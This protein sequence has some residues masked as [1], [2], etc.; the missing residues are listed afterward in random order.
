M[1][2]DLCS[3]YRSDYICPRH[4][5]IWKEDRQ[6]A[7]YKYSVMIERDEDGMYIASAP[8]IRGCYA[9]GKTYPEAMK[10]IR[11]ATRLHIDAR[12]QLGEP[13]PVERGFRRVV[14]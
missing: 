14:G 11:D 6:T 2:V 1:S 10:N 8:A 3:S 4:I 12:N 7:G 13:V 9:Q 5:N